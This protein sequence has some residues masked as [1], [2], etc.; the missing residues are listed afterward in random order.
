MV[1]YLENKVFLQVKDPEYRLLNLKEF[2]GDG[3]L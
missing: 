2:K 1:E 3:T